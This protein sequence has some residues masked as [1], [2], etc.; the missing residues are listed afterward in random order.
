MYSVRSHVESVLDKDNR[1]TGMGMGYGVPA[2]AGMTEKGIGFEVRDSNSELESHTSFPRSFATFGF[3]HQWYEPPSLH[4]HPAPRITL[5]L[6]FEVFLITN[7][8]LLPPALCLR[9]NNRS[10][11][12]QPRHPLQLQHPSE[13]WHLF[14]RRCCQGWRYTHREQGKHHYRRRQCKC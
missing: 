6:P 1:I 2:F 12:R 3:K 11:D 13:K 7:F 5:L 10:P 8:C 9:T 4:P 14:I